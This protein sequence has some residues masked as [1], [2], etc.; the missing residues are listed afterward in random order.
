M[1]LFVEVVVAVAVVFA[2]ASLVAGRLD[3]LTEAPPDRAEYQLPTR[4]LLP[5]DVDRTRLGLAFRGYRM[6][7]VDDVLDRLADELTARDGELA[8]RE[9]DAASLHEHVAE[10]EDRLVRA[11]SGLEAIEAELDAV[12]KNSLE[13]PMAPQPYVTTTF[14]PILDRAEPEPEPDAQ[15]EPELEPEPAPDAQPDPEPDPEPRT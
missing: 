3:G 13:M 4:R 11:E 5:V 9:R 2:V 7:E 1:L 6:A 15:P 12:R 14:P 10:L 8:Q